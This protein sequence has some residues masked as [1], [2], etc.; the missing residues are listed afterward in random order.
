MRIGRN[1]LLPFLLIASCLLFVFGNVP[2]QE[3]AE[4]AFEKAIYYEDVQG[5]LQKAIGLYEQILKQFPEFPESR[6]I[7][8]KAQLHIGLC[9]EKLG[10]SEAIKAYNQVLA[11]FAD[12]TGQVA[13]ARERLAALQAKKPS[14]QS[15]ATLLEGMRALEALSLSPDGKKL[16]VSHVSQGQNIAVYDLASKKLDL[17]TNF[18]WQKGGGPMS[19][20][21]CWSPDGKEI[22]FQQS[23]WVDGYTKAEDPAEIAVYHL[24]GN[25]RVIYRATN[26]KESHPLPYDWLDDGSAVLICLWHED[27]TGTLGLIPS[28]GGSFKALHELKGNKKESRAFFQQIADA[29]PDGRFVV[30][31]DRNS[32]GKHDLYIIGTDGASPEVLS[33]HPADE[34]MPRWSPD[35]KHIV[36]KSKRSGSMALWGI[37]VSD[38]KPVGEPF[39][40][41]KGNYSLL[42]WTKQGLAY[43][44]SVV[45]QDIFTVSIDPDSL[46]I[47]GKPRQIEYTPTGRHLCPSW[48]PDGKHLAFAANV[49]LPGEKKIVILSI[50]TGESREFS[51]PDSAP[52]VSGI[53][54]LH[55]L[56]D[57]SGLSFSG[58]DD[59]GNPALFQIDFKN[60]NAEWKKWPIPV[61]AWT[62][63][64]LSRDGKSFLFVRHGFSEDEPGIVEQ[65]LKTGDERYVYRPDKGHGGVFR[66]LKLS[67]DYTKL[68]FLEDNK[69]IKLV[70]IKTGEQRDLATMKWATVAWSPNGEKLLSTGLFKKSG[71]LFLLSVTDGSVRKLDLDVPKDSTVY[72]PAWSPDGRK[73]AF[74]LETGVWKL[75]L[76]KNIANK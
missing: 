36:F 73:I 59:D 72:D 18:R 34:R 32:Q 44:E 45:L 4:E 26:S 67:R 62:R 56:P 9:Y 5:D 1:I 16:A 20:R 42:N 51:N 7:A 15:S 29:S 2:S 23:R 24:D 71:G 43:R 8:A 68:A 12:Q 22:A 38:G 14:D 25:I 10:N 58:T 63:T 64:E 31:Q 19:F 33:D 48:S 27:D 6:E 57:G 65:N 41:K 47:K 61:K 17:I 13:A 11:N 55:W 69:L 49:H 50:E 30:F 46:E 21:P 75:H 76:M 40:V 35:G 70:D 53:Q 74:G 37:E 52:G 28:S 66:S 39:F 60:A 54:D 3:S